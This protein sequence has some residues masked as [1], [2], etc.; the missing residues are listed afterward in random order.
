VLD[1]KESSGAAGDGARPLA[2]V[3][4]KFGAVMNRAYHSFFAA[5][6]GWLVPFGGSLTW[7]QVD[8]NGFGYITD[9]AFLLFWP[10]LFTVLGWLVVGLPIAVTISDRQIR[11]YGL[12]VAVATAATT[13]T[14]LGIA[15]VFQF[16]L[17]AMMWWP[18]LTG[19]LGGSVFWFLQR[20]QPFPGWVWGLI[21]IGFL[22]FVRFVLLPLGLAFFPYTTHV[23]AEGTIGQEALYAV[24]ERVQVGDTYAELHRRYPAIFDE[25]VLDMSSASGNGWSYAITFDQ[26]CHRVTKVELRQH[27]TARGRGANARPRA[28]HH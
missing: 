8:E 13:A 12:L 9:F 16:D 20:Y 22:P 14:Y 7:M 19:L 17:L 26:D 6:V 10:L 27:H 18:V 28:A 4:Y 11:S 21:P 2:V 15:A 5:F 24:L 3:A 1:G 23:L 25:P